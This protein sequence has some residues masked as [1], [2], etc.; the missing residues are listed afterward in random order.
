MSYQFIHIE[1]YSEATKKVSGTDGHFNS[2]AQVLGEALRE[3]E[4]SKHVAEPGPVYKVGGTMSVR[5]LQEKRTTILEGL[6]ETVTRTDGTTYTRKLRSDAATL[7][8]EIHSHPLPAADLLSDKKAHGSDIREWINL[9]L[10]DFTA[11]MPDDIDW[12]AVMHLDEG[13]VHFHIIAIN[14]HDPKLDANKLH[15]GKV[16]AAML[17]DELDT[18]TAIPSLPKPALEKRPNKPK[19]PRPSKNR[20]TQK[21]NKIKREAQLA[22]W[23]VTCKEVAARNADLMTQWEAENGEHLQVARKT[24]GPIPEKEAYSAALKQLQDQ[25]YEKVGKPCGLLRDGPRKQRLSTQ[26][27][28]AQKAAA[29]DMKNSIKEVKSNL[30]RAEDNAGHALDVKERY[31][32]K[33]A[34]LDAGIAAMDE[35]VTQIAS[36]DAEVT[37]D[38]IIMKDTPTFIERLFGPKPSNTK[39]GNLFRKFVNLI[40]R[41]SESEQRGPDQSSRP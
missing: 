37:E 23:E 27:H 21:K 9:A 40:G 38:V 2:A 5:Q 29:K 26:Q 8:T 16:A 6:R 14:T 7:Y 24:R 10:A 20:E 19:Q 15:A 18:P 17:R 30:V 31:L 39:I 34:E 11:R 25:Y 3:P 32:Q 22:A 13:F 41:V 1:T 35:L 12:S 4:Y 33:E 28:A 36:G